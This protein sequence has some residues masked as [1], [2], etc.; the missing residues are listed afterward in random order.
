MDSVMLRQ[1]PENARA[2]VTVRQS[3]TLEPMVSLQMVFY[4]FWQ[5]YVGSLS[6][7]IGYLKYSN[8]TRQK[9]DPVLDDALLGVIVAVSVGVPV[10]IVVIIVCLIKKRKGLH[11]HL[12][13]GISYPRFFIIP[14]IRA[15]SI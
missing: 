15:I 13:F 9:V 10:I 2:S 8:R 12:N 7:V 11:S 3:L 14:P 1:S 6:Y 5:V 4:P